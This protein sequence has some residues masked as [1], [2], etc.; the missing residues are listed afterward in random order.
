MGVSLLVDRCI[1]GVLI[2][3]CVHSSTGMALVYGTAAGTV[4]VVCVAVFIREV[5]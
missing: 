3:S 4:H 2:T 5:H 1:G